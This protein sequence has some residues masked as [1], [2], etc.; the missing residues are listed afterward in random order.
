MSLLGSPA[1][2]YLQSRSLSRMSPSEWDHARE[3]RFLETAFSPSATVPNCADADDDEKPRLVEEQEEEEEEFYAGVRLKSPE[4]PTVAMCCDRRVC[5]GGRPSDMLAWQDKRQV[6]HIEASM[7]QQC[8]EIAQGQN[9]AYDEQLHELDWEH[10]D[11]VAT[12]RRFK[13]QASF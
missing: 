11:Q 1:Q 3:E 8:G 7:I 6:Q 9:E 12:L 13:A 2:R 10:R 5:R 4:V